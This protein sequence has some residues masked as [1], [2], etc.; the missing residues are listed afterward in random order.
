ML[1]LPAYLKFFVILLSLIM[2]VFVMIMARAML[3]PLLLA[4]IFAFILHPFSRLLERWKFPRSLAAIVSMVVILAALFFTFYFISYQ[5]GSISRDLSAIGTKFQG[6]IDQGHDWLE[7]EFGVEQSEQVSYIKNSLN[8][9]VQSST[10]IL[11]STLSATADFFTSFVLITISLFFLLYYRSFFLAFLY[12]VV[13]GRHHQTLEL[14][15][16]RVASVVR[17]YVLGL[18]IVIFILAVLNT[19]GLMLFGIEHAMFFGVLAALLTIIPY[20]GIFIG[21][22]LPILFALLTT[23]SLW[24]PIGIAIMFWAI[25]FIEGN[26]I[27]PN[28]VGNKV[29]LNPFAVIMALFAGGM[30]W[31]AIGMILAIPIVAALKVIFDHVESLRPYGF[32]L[33][34]PPEEKPGEPDAPKMDK[35]DKIVKKVKVREKA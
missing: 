16:N 29:S 9:F 1:K 2:L 25:Q 6:F 35:I 18:F 13:D 15:I 11:S 12:R 23:D 30:I 20:I 10:S 4:L 17:S 21:S 8:K 22:V 3:V 5:V 28:I 31:G 33:G 14:T 32:L 34:Y 7:T 26:F 19:T 24:Y 27:T